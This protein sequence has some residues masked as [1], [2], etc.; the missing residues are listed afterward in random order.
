MIEHRTSGDIFDAG[1]QAITNTINCVGVMGKGLALQ[2]KQR[3]PEMFREY[4][5]LCRRKYIQ[6]GKVWIWHEIPV[7]I[8]GSYATHPTDTCEQWTPI[9]EYIVNFP[10]KDDWRNASK[11]EWIA[12]GLDDLRTCVTLGSIVS[13][14]LPA[15]GCQ[16]GGL[17]FDDV[18][19]LIHE[20]LDD[21][22]IP[23]V[24]YEP[25]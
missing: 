17:R 19:K 8:C 2:F 20:K 24:L 10:T 9:N 18:Q 11:L 7:C 21:L 5:K 22:S 13:L 15:L 12:A 4:A 3:Y 6:V 14:A 23:I 25:Q 16:N 1:T